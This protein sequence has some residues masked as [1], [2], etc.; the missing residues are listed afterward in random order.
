MITLQHSD[1]REAICFGIVMEFF[2]KLE[3]FQVVARDRLTINQV[4]KEYKLD[5]ST[6]VWLEDFIQFVVAAVHVSHS[7]YCARDDVV[8]LL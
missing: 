4:S 8:T 2:D 7:H 6:E 1:F 3:Y 5:T